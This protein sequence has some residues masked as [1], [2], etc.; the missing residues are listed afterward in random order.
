MK[1][2]GYGLT[3]CEVWDNKDLTIEAKAIYGFLCTYADKQG[4]AYP[5]VEQMLRTLNIS[6]ARFYK[7]MNLLVASGVVK[8]RMVY[9]DGVREKAVYTLIPNQNLQLDNVTVDSL[10]V[11]NLDSNNTNINNTNINNTSINVIC[12]LPLKSGEEY[13]VK[14]DYVNELTKAYPYIDI[15]AEFNKMRAWCLSNPDK[16]KTLKGIRRFINSWLSKAGQPMVWNKPQEED[17]G[18]SKA[19]LEGARHDKEVLEGY[20]KGNSFTPNP[21]DAFQ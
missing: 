16:R 3:Y 20:F 8:K 1:R 14:Q 9:K 7:H 19:Y 13:G 4:E 2:Q 11:D 6:R 17:Y 18:S 12:S 5:S 15:I 21:D 10:T